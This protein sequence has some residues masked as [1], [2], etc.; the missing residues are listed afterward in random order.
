MTDAEISMANK[1]IGKQL[2]EYRI[3]KSITQIQIA[4]ECNTTKSTISRI[5]TG[6]KSA[7]ISVLLAYSKLLKMQLKDLVGFEN[8]LNVKKEL[9]VVT[10][11]F[12][13]QPT[14]RRIA[15]RII[16]DLWQLDPKAKDRAEFE[17][18]EHTKDIFSI[19]E[20]GSTGPKKGA[21]KNKKDSSRTEAR[22]G[23]KD[24][25]EQAILN[26]IQR[27]LLYRPAEVHPA[28]ILF[29]NDT[30][31][32]ETDPR[33]TALLYNSIAHMLN[34]FLN[35]GTGESTTNTITPNEPQDSSHKE[36]EG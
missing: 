6:K 8:D 20:D 7:D 12:S 15:Y 23:T 11:L 28:D 24:D 4:E 31:S 13:M 14:Y 5:E 34:T 26:M 35:K 29:V 2:R 21:S 1:Q 9:G 25:I 16:Y 10:C 27:K 3:A 30:N 36:D 22:E 19:N 33:E 18:T 17:T 32:Q